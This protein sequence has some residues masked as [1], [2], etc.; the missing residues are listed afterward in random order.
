MK[1][2]E[3][4]ERII[5]KYAVDEELKRLL[6]THS[7]CVAAK[8]LRVADNAGIGER[9]DRRFVWDAAMLHDIGIVECD[10]PG[11]HCHGQQPYI[12]HG[13]AGSRILN[14]EGLPEKY[15]RVCERHTGSGLTADEIVAHQLPLPVRDY[16]PETLEEKLICYADKFF[17]KSGDPTVEKSHDR[18]VASISRHGEAPLKRFL[19]LEKLFS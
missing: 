1:S 16:L 9:I 8:A 17:S 12:C 15:G 11:I 10:A 14:A 19:K 2:S 13:I 3:F 6:I 4:V 18:V 7:Q 5:D